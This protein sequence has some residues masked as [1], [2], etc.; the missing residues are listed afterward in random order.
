MD[1]VRDRI[2]DVV[3][4]EERAA[5]IR[6]LGLGRER[7]RL[8]DVDGGSDGIEHH[9][10]EEASAA[11][12]GFERHRVRR[13]VGAPG[14]LDA[15]VVEERASTR[16]GLGRGRLVERL[17]ERLVGRLVGR[18]RHSLDDG[19]VDV[20]DG[21]ADRGDDLLRGLEER[22]AGTDANALGSDERRAGGERE[23]GGDGDGAGTAKAR[24]CGHVCASEATSGGA[25]GRE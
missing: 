2:L 22:A 8:R 9:V 3:V 5:A 1:E 10:A 11:M 17:V 6:G 12:R 15:E 4:L 25:R 18:R 21:L 13:G 24:E 16:E 23:R 7:G 20:G 14:A 19:V